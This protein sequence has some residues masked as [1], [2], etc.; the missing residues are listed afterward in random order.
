VQP[1]PGTPGGRAANADWAGQHPV[2]SRNGREVFYFNP[3]T[4]RIMVATYAAKGDAFSAD[5][6]RVW[7]DTQIFENNGAIW[8]F[9]LALDGKRVVASPRAKRRAEGLGARDGAG[10][11]LRRA[12]AEDA[13]GEVT[14]PA[15]GA[16][17]TSQQPV[18]QAQS[19]RLQP[20]LR[21][22]TWIWMQAY[23][24]TVSACSYACMLCLVEFRA[25]IDRRQVAGVIRLRI[26]VI[27]KLMQRATN[28]A[29]HP[30]KGPD[31]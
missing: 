23:E 11:F 13:G 30:K 16:N 20:C 17:I 5:K 12:A 28:P 24:T 21:D 1:F 14:A 22:L 26:V 10:E 4:S 8:N 19:G 25:C 15:L 2:W 6:S 29:L 27:K 31:E 3:A 18:T 7:S 9:D